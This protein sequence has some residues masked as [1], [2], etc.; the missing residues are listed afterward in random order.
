MVTDIDEGLTPLEGLWRVVT[1]SGSEYHLTLDLMLMT[2]LPPPGAEHQLRW[3]G[4]YVPLTRVEG[5]A[6][7]E[8]MLL[9]LAPYG[10]TTVTFRFTSP[11][12]TLERLTGDERAD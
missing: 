9:V 10:V 6:V 11:V 12:T 5:W 8:P 4:D 1:E 2:R 3:D 7:G